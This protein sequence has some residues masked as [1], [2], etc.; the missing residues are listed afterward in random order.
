MSR[1]CLTAEGEVLQRQVTQHP[2]AQRGQRP[3]EPVGLE[4]EPLQPGERAYQ[5]LPRDLLDTS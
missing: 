2:L 3:S 5:T 4:V 1:K